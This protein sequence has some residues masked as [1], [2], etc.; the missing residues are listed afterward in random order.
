MSEA[1]CISEN[2]MNHIGWI[3]SIKGI[4]MIMIFVVHCVGAAIPEFSEY[5]VYGQY[6]V[7]LFLLCSGFM[8]ELKSD[9]I[10]NSGIIRWLVRKVS[11]IIPTLWLFM[12]ITYF[13]NYIELG[14]SF[15]AL[16]YL[17]K[18]NRYA[19]PGAV[20]STL[21]C[22]NFIY[23]KWDYFSFFTGTYALCM[24]TYASIYLIRKYIVQIS[25]NVITTAFLLSLLVVSC[26]KIDNE[27]LYYWCQYS[28]RGLSAFYSGIV[29]AGFI[30]NGKRKWEAVQDGFFF[31]L[32]SLLI[33]SLA[34]QSILFVP[35]WSS[36]YFILYSALFIYCQIRSGK[37]WVVWDNLFFR[38]IGKYSFPF[39]FVHQI[40]FY[41]LNDFIR[42]RGGVLI[43][44]FTISLI[45]SALITIVYE[46]N[47]LA[48]LRRIM[49]AQI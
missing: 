22:F 19:S 42:S 1:V 3:D 47:L 38:K 16:S 49:R 46:R 18:N 33:L 48:I 25:N 7:E 29:L 5:T 37:I 21:F 11:R 35:Q 32:S 15:N 39:Y 2:K 34:V 43:V 41:A 31:S 17:M 4:A 13:L 12:I 28:L 23:P 24:V 20:I 8:S 45:I 30:S 9:S 6:G 26:F 36:V 40:C 44:S 10:E 27:V 14:K